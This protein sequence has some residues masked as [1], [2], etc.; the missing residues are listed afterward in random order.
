MINSTKFKI[1]VAFLFVLSQPIFALD[2][3]HIRASV[4]TFKEI[5][6]FSKA[7]PESPKHLIGNQHNDEEAD[8]AI[9]VF[10]VKN[11]EKALK[12]PYGLIIPS[13]KKYTGNIIDAAPAPSVNFTAIDDNGMYI[14]PDVNGAVG[15]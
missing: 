5:E 3:P 1:L 2:P 12:D 8:E 11:A 15:P 6:E 7:H 9:P 14:P 10:K 13:T 4:I